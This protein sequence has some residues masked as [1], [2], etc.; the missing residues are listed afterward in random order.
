MRL[1]HVIAIASELGEQMGIKMVESTCKKRDTF[2]S[3]L[4]HPFFLTG[5]GINVVS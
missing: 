2:I 4:S 3:N 5:F 1:L